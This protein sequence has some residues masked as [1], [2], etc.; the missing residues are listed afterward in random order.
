MI[1]N[2]L[3]FNFLLLTS[4]LF[5]IF[6]PSP[7]YALLWWILLISFSS[8]FILSL[9]LPFLA[10]SYFI[11]YIG[12]IVILF[13]FVIMTLHNY[14]CAQPSYNYYLLLSSLIIFWGESSVGSPTLSTAFLKDILPSLAT[15]LYTSYSFLWYPTSLLLLLSLFFPIFLLL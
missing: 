14:F 6:S 4:S 3:P 8:L 12:A 10:F 2:Y 9:G 13:L 11:L 7:L 15:P 1:Q 5:L